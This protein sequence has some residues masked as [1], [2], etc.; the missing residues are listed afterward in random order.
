MG[1]IG[2]ISKVPAGRRPEAASGAN[3]CRPRRVG[4]SL[5]EGMVGMVIF[6][7]IFTFTMRAFTPTATDTHNL[8]R[9]H[10]IAMDGCSWYLND[11]EKRINYYGT[12]PAGMMG[13]SDITAAFTPDLFPDIP[14]LRC[15]K[16]VADVEADG[17]LF[18][19][20]VTFQW[21]NNDQDVKRPHSFEMSR[22]KTRPGL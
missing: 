22:W 21:G 5:L 13:Q 3:A 20:K 17:D 18:K 6:M 10:T 19:L 16:V 14:F 15:L 8:I 4:F 7:L 2:S 9:G 12:L 11:L 1:S